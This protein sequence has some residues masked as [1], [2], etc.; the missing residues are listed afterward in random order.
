[1]K[2]RKIAVF[3]AVCL[4]IVSFSGCSSDMK[5][6]RQAS[7]DLEAEKYDE[8]LQ[9][10]ETAIA[11]GV[12]PA[13]S[14][15]GAG[16]A[17]VH[18]GNYKEAIE[19]FTDALN[20]KKVGKSLKKDILSYR[21]AAYLKIKAYDEAMAD[22]QSIAADYDMD[23]DVYFLTG[24]V[25]LAMD[26]YEEASTDFEQAYGE[27]ATY[28]MAIR[29][30]SA[31][32][33]KDMEADGTRYLEAALAKTADNAQDHCDRGRVYYYMSDYDNA[34]KEL[35]E[36]AD[37]GNTEAVLLREWFTWNRRILPV[38]ERNLRNMYLRQRTV[39]EALMVWLSVILRM[40]IMTVLF[41]IFPVPS[42][43]QKE[44]N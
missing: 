24:E 33:E 3:L 23:A 21:A 11:A 1:M 8:A 7:S 34:Q 2:N 4:G 18:L 5:N 36:A 22:C 27:E 26:S 28:D 14:Y 42:P 20:C 39:P 16:V 19:N 38:P 17:N 44:R 43:L 37:D 10:F 12:N 40:E 13:G 31:Y 30:Y 29:I 35:Q 32:L 25:A 41:P 15:R 6:Y 9:E